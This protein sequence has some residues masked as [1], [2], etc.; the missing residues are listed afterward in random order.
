MALTRRP[1]GADVALA[2]HSDAGSQYTAGVFQQLLDDHR[3]LA[4][5]G[6]VGDACDNAMA[7]SFVNAIQTELVHDRVFAS[8]RALELA[9][10]AWIG[11]YN[12]DRLHSAIGDKPPADHERA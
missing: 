8:R 11:W 3:M 2:H 10:V 4:S 12:H 9:V 7:E 1:A 6:P 5:I